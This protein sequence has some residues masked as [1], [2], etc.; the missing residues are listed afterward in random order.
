MNKLILLLACVPAVLAAPA[1]AEPWAWVFYPGKWNQPPGQYYGRLTFDIDG[2]VTAA[3]LF[4]S[5]DN[6]TDV[7]LNGQPVGGSGDWYTLKPITLKT[8]Q[9]LLKPGRNVL[10]AHVQNDDYEGGFICKGMILLGSGKRIELNSGKRWRC[11]DQPEKDWNQVDFDDS[12]WKESEVIGTPPAGPWGVPTTPPSRMAIGCIKIGDVTSEQAFKYNCPAGGETVT[13]TLEYA[14]GAKLTATGR[15][16]QGSETFM[17]KPSATGYLVLRRRLAAG[18]AGDLKVQV[19]GKDAGIWHSAPPPAG[20]WADALFVVPGDLAG[21]PEIAI[22]LTPEKPG[23]YVSYGYEFMLSYEWYMLG[24]RLTGAIDRDALGRK[25]QEEPDNAA[26]AFCYGLALEAEHNWPQA[27]AAYRRCAELLGAGDLAESALR[28]ARLTRAMQALASAGGDGGKLYTIGL[29]LKANGFY[30]EAAAAFRAASER[31]PTAEVYDQL[32]EALLFA[33][34]TPQAC[35]EAWKTGL[36]QFPPQST[37]RWT[38][39]AELRPTPEQRPQVEPQEEQMHLM[40]DF[41]YCSSRGRMALEVKLLVDPPPKEQLYKW[42]ELDSFFT[43]T[44]VAAGGGTLGPDVTYGN[45]GW[46]GFGFVTTWGVAWHEWIHQL[47]CGLASSGNG[48]GWGGDHGSTQFGYRPPW[49]QWYRA[50]MRYYITPGGYQ[51]VCISDHWAAPYADK[52]LVKGPFVG[53][54][55]YPYWLCFPGKRTANNCS[56]NTRKMITLRELPAKATL[57]ATGDNWA[58]LYVNGRR[59]GDSGSWGSAPTIDIA[60]DLAAGENVVGIAANNE[61]NEG[62][63]LAC[64]M[65]TAKDGTRT[66]I[67]TDDTWKTEETRDDVRDQHHNPPAT[68]GA[69]T[70]PGF[71]DSAWKKPEV[72]GRYPC[73]PWNRI[74]IALPD[75]L[76]TT[77]FAGPSV[78]APSA[79][80]GW[81]VVELKEKMAKLGEIA[82]PG[83]AHQ[84]VTYFFTYAYAP[85]DLRAQMA[86]G[87]AGRAV[88]TLNGERQ[89]QAGGGGHPTLPCVQPVSLKQG[90]NR[91]LLQVEDLGKAGM[92]WA[93][94]VQPN[95]QA[96]EGLTYANEKPATGLVGDQQ[97]LPKFDPAKPKTYRWADVCDDPY[98]LLPRMTAADLAAHTG[99]KNLKMSGG[100]DFLFIDLGGQ[101]PPAGY[102]PLTAYT[103]GEHEPNNALTWDFEPLAVVRFAAGGKPRDLVFVKPD[104][105]VTVFESQLVKG[106]PGSTPAAEKV[107]GWVLENGRLCLV[108][109]TD[110]G[111]LPA[112]TMDLLTVE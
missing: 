91:V 36:K 54:D 48:P 105:V 7:H 41:I 44:G 24:E 77:D 39:I 13:T 80:D 9:P 102:T 64:L 33:G 4:V 89:F 98:T 92:F 37:N 17:V 93:K 84:T 5:G 59:V 111:P 95:G 106:A 72:I 87:S 30:A 100:N 46:S 42:G 68:V 15:R 103:G 90:W 109:E 50:A 35:L 112:Q 107:L 27:E 38:S 1:G 99:Y 8:M 71:D 70:K 81:R 11:T 88:V 97:T 57:A 83:D 86:V 29:Y 10:A 6:F 28:G 40:E 43:L 85:R 2:E 12:A 82:P 65:L 21:K 58:V 108:A 45:A 66:T 96:I 14:D 20:K 61:D 63:V 75:T 62:G 79:A 74:S 22:T 101:Q 16:V 104:A 51:R 25:R 69:W 53:H 19:E 47:E 56:W 18:Q 23:A 60:K 52:W 110:L 78:A 34:E 55:E 32:G 73:G 76:M 26:T 31:Q 3:C 67:G 94:L 49:W